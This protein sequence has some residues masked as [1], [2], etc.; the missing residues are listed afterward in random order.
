[1]FGHNPYYFSTIRKLTVYFGTIFNNIY[2]TRADGDNTE[3][4]LMRVPLQ[5]GPKDKDFARINSD[6]NIDREVAIQLPRMSFEL[7]S[8][9]YDPSRKL[10]TLG[11][12]VRKDSTDAD[13]FRRMYNPVPYNFMFTLSIYV[14]NVEDGTKIVEQI[15]PFFT[16]EFTST[17]NLIPEMNISMDLPIVLLD[18]SLEDSYEGSF[19]ERRMIIWTMNFMIKGFLFGPVLSKPIIKFSNTDFYIGNTTSTNTTISSIQV[20]PGLDANG[21]PTSNASISVNTNIIEVDDNWDYIVQQS[22]IYFYNT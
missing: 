19:D 15:L 4:H 13:K 1:M 22:G 8:M 3:T 12:L 14:K 20:K 9:Q 5:Y 11:R 17:V 6:P 16:P 2:I 18:T 7:T 10:G 21:N